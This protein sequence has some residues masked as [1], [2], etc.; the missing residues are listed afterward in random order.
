MQ[1]LRALIADL[2]VAEHLPGLGP[3]WLIAACWLVD[4]RLLPRLEKLRPVAYCAVFFAMGL[5]G[6]V[7]LAPTRLRLPARVL[8]LFAMAVAAAPYLRG[9]VLGLPRSWALDNPDLVLYPA[10]AASLLA[11][12]AAVTGGFDA[13]AHGIGRGDWRW[14]GPR[15]GALVAVVVGFGVLA[16]LSI[17]QLRE[18]YPADRDA[19][20]DLGALFVAQAG[21]GLYLLVEEFFWHGLALFALARTHGPRAAVWI[22]SFLYFATHHSKPELEMAS[23]LLGALLLGVGC[24]RARSFWPAFLL[25]WPLNITVD[26]TAFFLMGPRTD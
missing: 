19:R 4:Q 20:R 17:P 18:Y 16:V 9:A 22:T 13:E 14:W 1:R 26:L 23:S 12:G 3:L 2:R 24:L 25:H 10:L 5:A 7:L 15:V 8:A 21:R 11:V 6:F